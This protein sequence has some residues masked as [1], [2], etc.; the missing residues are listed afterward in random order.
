MAGRNPGF[1]AMVSKKRRYE[2]TLKKEWKIR[3]DDGWRE[4][5]EEVSEE[6]G[7]PVEDVERINTAW[8]K[9]VGEMMCRVE[10]PRIRMDYLC[11]LYPSKAKLYSYC[12]KMSRIISRIVNGR[13]KEGVV[14]GDVGLMKKHLV[15]LQD[16][17][18]RLDEEGKKARVARG[19]SIEEL[20]ELGARGKVP[21][22]DIRELRKLKEQNLKKNDKQE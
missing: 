18:F 19:H 16:T 11:T 15:R 5:M 8:W 4:I 2:W 22:A 3:Y 21:R 9:F 13:Y 14:V 12:E 1:K 10:M 17:Y 20:K 7:I 6:V